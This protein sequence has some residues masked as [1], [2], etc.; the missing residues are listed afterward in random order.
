MHFFYNLTFPC[1][2]HYFKSNLCCPD[3]ALLLPL[4]L[5]KRLLNVNLLKHYLEENSNKQ[6]LVLCRL[7]NCDERCGAAAGHGAAPPARG[8]DPSCLN[9]AHLSL[10]LSNRDFT[11][12]IYTTL[13]SRM[14]R[15]EHFIFT[16]VIFDTE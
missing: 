16:F 11:L 4:I 14:L 7:V 13:G 9:G 10:Y 3:T 5:G 6:L 8:L 1:Y 15:I 12:Y 2:F